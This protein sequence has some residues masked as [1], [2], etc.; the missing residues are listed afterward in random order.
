MNTVTKD[1]ADLLVDE[2]IGYLADTEDSESTGWPIYLQFQPKTPAKLVVLR[3]YEGPPPAVPLNITDPE[4]PLEN[5]R[6]QAAIRASSE[7]EAF[8]K[9]QE[10][11]AFLSNHGP[12]VVVITDSQDPDYGVNQVS[13]KHLVRITSPYPLATEERGVYIWVVSFKAARQLEAIPPG[14]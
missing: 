4:N 5:V 6:F 10:I 7:R 13:Y 1:I 9:A 11:A 2:E 12:F 14:D 3:E 8:L